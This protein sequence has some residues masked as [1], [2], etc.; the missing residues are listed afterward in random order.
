MQRSGPAIAPTDRTTSTHGE[1]DRPMAGLA[2]RPRP[3]EGHGAS[4]ER[5]GRG[6][7]LFFTSAVGLRRS[8]RCAVGS[9]GRPRRGVSVIEVN[10]CLTWLVGFLA[11]LDA[12]TVLIERRPG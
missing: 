12:D 11:A 10:A 2:P 6:S 8:P 3:I 4:G 9:F 1:G 7:Q 5:A